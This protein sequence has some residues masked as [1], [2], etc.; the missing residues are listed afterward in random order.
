MLI[1]FNIN[2][3]FQYFMGEKTGFTSVKM[4]PCDSLMMPTAV[5][6]RI[7]IAIQAKPRKKR[8]HQMCIL[9]A[10]LSKKQNSSIPQTQRF[11]LWTWILKALSNVLLLRIVKSKSLWMGLWNCLPALLQSLIG[12]CFRGGDHSATWS[13]CGV[14]VW[15]CTLHPLCARVMLHGKSRKWTWH[16]GAVAWITVTLFLRK[17]FICMPLQFIGIYI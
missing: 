3:A 4:W 10:S 16:C 11:K 12:S 6:Y 7:L 5:P 9:K 2:K 13:K 15:Q 8:K 14:F 1:L 17:A